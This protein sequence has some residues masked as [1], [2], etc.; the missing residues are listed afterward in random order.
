MSTPAPRWP[1]YTRIPEFIPVPVRARRDGWTAVR[2][3]EFIGMLAQ[4]GS[5]AEAAAWI[6]RSRESAWRLRKREGAEGFAAAWDF[7]AGAGTTE[8]SSRKVTPDALA[9]AAFEGTVRVLM[10]RGRYA[11]VRIVRRSSALL[12]LLAQIDRSCLGRLEAAAW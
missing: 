3:G 2:Q 5:V 9:A 8:V 11:G 7:A 1:A 6:G 12:R 4:T 10:R